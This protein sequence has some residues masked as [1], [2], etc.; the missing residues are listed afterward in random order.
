MRYWVCRWD[1]E[2]FKCIQNF[3]R[4]SLRKLLFGKL[5]SRLDITLRW[6]YMCETGR[7]VDLVV[8]SFGGRWFVIL[9][10][11]SF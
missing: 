3:R 10:I 8:V 1:E 5:D 6:V 4:E 2:N 9:A 7:G 11:F